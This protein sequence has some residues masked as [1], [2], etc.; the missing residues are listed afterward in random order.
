MTTIIKLKNSV[1]TTNAPSTL[2]QGEVAINVTDR[3][4]WVGN[5]ATTPVQLLGDGSTGSFTSLSV[6][7]VATFSAGTVSAPA[8]T[9]TGDTNTGIYFPAADTIAF[10]EGGVES[11]RIDASGQVGIG[12]AP[13]FTLDVYRSSTTSSL[14]VARNDTSTTAMYATSSASF[15]GTTTNTPFGFI[16]NNTERMRITSA[17][18]VGIGTSSPAQILDIVGTTPIINIQGGATTNA[19]G[20]NFAYNSA[21]SVIGSLISYGGTGELALS[22]GNSGSAGYFLTFSTFGVERMRVGDTGNVGIGTSSPA[23][24]LD[25]IGNGRFFTSGG[26]PLV[27]VNNGTIDHYIGVNATGGLVGTSNAYPLLLLTNNAE[28][29]RIDS[30]GNVGIGNTNPTNILDIAGEGQTGVNAIN[31]VWSTTSSGYAPIL[32]LKKSNGTKAS[33]TVVANG[34]QTGAIVFNGYDGSNYQSTAQIESRVDGTPGTNDM[35][36]RLV[37]LT[38]P[39]GSASPTERMRITSAGHLFVGT[40]TDP[41]SSTK[42]AALFASGVGFFSAI[43]QPVIYA[44][45]IDTDGT[46]VEFQRNGTVRGSISVSGSTTS[47]NTSS[48]YRLKE[49]IAPMT[50]ALAKVQALKPCTYKWKLNGLD[51]QG[52]IAHELQEVVPDCVSGEKDGE[53]MQGIDTSFLVATLTAAIQEQQT[54]ITSLTARIAALESN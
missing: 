30:S 2:Q 10:T 36:G 16:T 34:D 52:F 18:N 40:T 27:Q 38:T 32:N 26:S 24:K 7:G 6:S 8:I 17:G 48:D 13:S 33:P 45:R 14:V 35:P 51:G 41:G 50:G 22:A 11:M 28:R 1:T 43:D 12:I 23:Q 4:V 47:Y 37:F 53:Q 29:M 19:R 5:A 46:L 9:T 31:F 20:I 21:S 54:L 44:N 3:K 25:V 49:N 15:A 39:D 42:G